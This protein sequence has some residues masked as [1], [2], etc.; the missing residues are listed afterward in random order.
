M[1]PDLKPLFGDLKCIN[2]M[3]NKLLM[4][5]RMASHN[6]S[7]IQHIDEPGKWF[8]AQGPLHFDY[9]H[10]GPYAFAST[11]EDAVADVVRQIRSND[12]EAINASR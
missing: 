12:I 1:D 3:V 6:I 11:P 8:A 2:S 7:V 10:S 4:Q 5:N 9:G